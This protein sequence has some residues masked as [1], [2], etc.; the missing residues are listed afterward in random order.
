MFNEYCANEIISSE[1]Y[2]IIILWSLCFLKLCNQLLQSWWRLI[3][4]FNKHNNKMDYQ[5]HTCK[6]YHIPSINP[7][8][9]IIL[10]IFHS[11]RGPQRRGAGIKTDGNIARLSA[12]DDD[13]ENNT[14]NGNSTQQMWIYDYIYLE[15]KNY[16]IKIQFYT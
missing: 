16:S 4:N 11:N 3:D 6:K 10:S 1:N 9:I 7:R 2:Q 8:L 13:D 14:W 5:S 12:D 15:E